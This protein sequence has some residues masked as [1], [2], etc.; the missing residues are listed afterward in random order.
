MSKKIKYWKGVEELHQTPDFKTAEQKEFSEYL[1]VEDF[2]GDKGLMEGSKTSRR[3]FL[4]YLGFGVT[5]ASL[6]ACET[7]VQRVIPHV[8]KTDKT[9]PGIANYYATAYND[10]H[11]YCD[12]VVKTREGR[13]IKIEPNRT[14]PFTMGGINARVNSSVLSLY[15]GNRYKAPQINGEEVSWEEFDKD[16]AGKLTAALNG[17][18][19]RLLTSSLN[20]P[21]SQKMI[22]D[23]QGNAEVDFKHINYDAISSSGAFILLAIFLAAF[24]SCTK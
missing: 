24:N 8:M 21:S 5:A 2:V 4:K 22:A 15:D 14:S 19:V 7:P 23:L 1:P 6:A 11:D 10:G 20:S 9:N 12:I 3:D 17:G 13:P 18:K 16:V